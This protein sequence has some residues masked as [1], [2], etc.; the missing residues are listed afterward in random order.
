MFPPMNDALAKAGS[1]S[2]IHA[3]EDAPYAFHADCRSTYRKAPAEEGWNR[4]LAWLRQN[5]V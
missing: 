5:G 2:Q 3:Y 1:E 4:L